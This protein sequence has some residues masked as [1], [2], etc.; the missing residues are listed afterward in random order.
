MFDAAVEPLRRPAPRTLKQVQHR[1]AQDNY[2]RWRRM[3][4]D[5]KWMKK[6]LER[7]GLNPEDWRSYLD[8]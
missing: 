7:M 8:G 6:R 5:V 2:W 3:Q 4:H 1:L